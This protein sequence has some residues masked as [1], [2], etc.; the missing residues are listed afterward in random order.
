[1]G[2]WAAGRR[3]GA[4][5]IGGG[6]ALYAS[7]LGGTLLGHGLGQVIGAPER[8]GPGLPAGR[9]LR[10]H[11]G[12]PVARPWITGAISGRSPPPQCGRGGDPLGASGPLV[13]HWPADFRQ[14]GRGLAP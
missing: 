11:G 6:L 5:L 14:P 7:W 9:L 12:R 13:H 10:L 4:Y 8:L 3:D 2:E 1:M